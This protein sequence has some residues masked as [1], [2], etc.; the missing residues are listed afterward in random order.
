M[1]GTIGFLIQT[2]GSVGLVAGYIPQIVQLLKTKKSED[3][4]T[5]FWVILT[6]SLLCITINMVIQNTS[7]YIILTQVI[8]FLL[9]LITLILVKKYKAK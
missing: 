5:S 7:F 3:I 8:N 6:V 1:K 4:N 2:I 9:A